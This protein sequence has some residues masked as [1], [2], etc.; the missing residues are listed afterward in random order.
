MRY[1]LGVE[2]WEVSR[3]RIQQNAGPISWDDWER[4]DSDARLWRR[5]RQ[6]KAG[7]VRPLENP[8]PIRV[9]AGG[10]MDEGF[11]GVVSLMGLVVPQP[12]AN[13]AHAETVRTALQEGAD[14]V[15]IAFPAPP[16]PFN[17]HVSNDHRRG[18]TIVSEDPNII[19]SDI[20][21]GQEKGFAVTVKFRKAS[22]VLTVM[23]VGGRYIIRNGV[24]RA[25]GFLLAGWSEIPA[26]IL[27]VARWPHSEGLFGEEIVM[28]PSPPTVSDCLNERLYGDLDWR[29]RT[30]MW[31]VVVDEFAVPLGG[32]FD[33]TR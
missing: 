9:E 5:S 16:Y 30:R 23:A 20:E 17:V 22:P 32:E 8:P 21:W 29:T 3:N 24:H 13:M 1:L 10:G 11:P 31:R 12:I 4:R 2:S 33:D 28:D 25:L 19:I 14:P 7:D 6:W 27:P 15:G 18:C 26:F